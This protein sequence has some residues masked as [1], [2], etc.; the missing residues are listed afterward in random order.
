[1]GHDTRAPCRYMRRFAADWLKPGAVWPETRF[2]RSASQCFAGLDQRFHIAEDPAPAT[3]T[4]CAE[5][6]RNAGRHHGR[7][8]QLMRHGEASESN[9][10]TFDFPRDAR[11]TFR[12]VLL[13]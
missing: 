3:T 5:F 4:A 13:G 1:M 10:G 2:S 8:L 12:L 9:F 6:A 7:A 11:E